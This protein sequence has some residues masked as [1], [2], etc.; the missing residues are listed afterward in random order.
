MLNKEWMLVTVFEKSPKNVLS[1]KMQHS[2]Q[3]DKINVIGCVT[4]AIDRKNVPAKNFEYWRMQL[5]WGIFKHCVTSKGSVAA[6][7]IGSKWEKRK[8]ARELDN[9]VDCRA[10]FTPFNY[11]VKTWDWMEILLQEFEYKVAYRNFSLI[12]R[13]DQ[14]FFRWNWRVELLERERYFSYQTKVRKWAKNW[15]HFERIV[16][17]PKLQGNTPKM[18]FGSCFTVVVPL[19]GK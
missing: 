2:Y 10:L 14:R 19:Y 8:K 6:F 17:G 16:G 11:T 13:G 4:V 5:F 9:L 18:N 7:Y 3:V 12:L 15:T 1:L